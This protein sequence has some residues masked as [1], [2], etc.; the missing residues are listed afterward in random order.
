MSREDMI[1]VA[2]RLFAI[3]L[4]FN[5]LHQVPSAASMAFADDARFWP[6]VF[7]AS[8][9][10]GFML[11]A[12]LWTFPLTIARR[13]LPVMRTPPTSLALDSRMAMTVGISLMGLWFLA[14]AILDATY[15]GMVWIYAKRLDHGPL[16]FTHDQWAG[17][18]VTV[19]EFAIALVLL[20]GANGIRA[21]IETLRHGGR[22]YT[23]T[24]PH[25]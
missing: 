22:R 13:L 1:A 2:T 14:G 16:H 21:V 3:Y 6:V 18:A 11:C 20:L 9:L 15:W 10:A 25:E 5:I 19:I 17:I 12:L 24:I 8:L 7:G 4:L 23:D